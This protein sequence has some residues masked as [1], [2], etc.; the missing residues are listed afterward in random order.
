MLEA[1]ISSNTRVKLL[2]LFLLNPG[3]E[4][5]LREI[6]RKAEENRNAVRRELA[7]LESFGLITSQKKGNQLYYT[8]NTGHY[9]Y[10][11]L[12]KIVL[13]TEGVAGTLREALAGEDI[14]C[15]FIYGSYARGTPTKK[16]DID[17]FIIGA[18][19]EDRLIPVIHSCEQATGREINYTLMSE[20]EFLRRK[21]DGDPFVKNVLQ[22]EKILICGSC[23][24]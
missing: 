4:F 2:T 8:V 24:D 6:V 17:L 21:K 1:L 18:V 14:A 5:Y 3:S 20:S 12:Q 13:K 10:A 19:E 7:N 23:D 15:V 22:E 11:D 9:L 16:S